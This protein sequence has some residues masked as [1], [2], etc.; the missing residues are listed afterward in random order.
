MDPWTDFKIIKLDQV[1]EESKQLGSIIRIFGEWIAF[2]FKM[3]ENVRVSDMK[4]LVKTG[5][6]VMWDAQMSQ[7]SKMA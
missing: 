2:D 6:V 7:I 4:E 3:F 1:G 5:D